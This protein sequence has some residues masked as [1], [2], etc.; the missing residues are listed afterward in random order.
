M[1]RDTQMRNGGCLGRVTSMYV[2]AF[3]PPR[4]VADLLHARFR[5]LLGLVSTL[6][7]YIMLVVS[8]DNITSDI[9][10]SSCT[11]MQQ[12]PMLMAS[13]STRQRRN[14]LFMSSACD[15]YRT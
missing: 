10:L 5:T 15:V 4:V 6:H 2:A 13:R 9:S 7:L 3:D 11:G 1:S 8:G 12:K 14:T